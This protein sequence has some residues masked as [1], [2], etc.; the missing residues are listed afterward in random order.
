MQIF[1]LG[2][3]QKLSGI[4]ALQMS[5]DK[6]KGWLYCKR[7]TGGRANSVLHHQGILSAWN[8]TE[9]MMFGEHQNV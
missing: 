6:G 9:N 8:N 7:G 2:N 3:M 4:K 1:Y 5:G